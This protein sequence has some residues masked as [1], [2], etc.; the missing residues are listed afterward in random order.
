MH[1]TGHN[2]GNKEQGEKFASEELT[3]RRHL[4]VKKKIVGLRM[5]MVF[6]GTGLIEQP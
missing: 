2:G 5:E 1:L 4:W 3:A 6:R